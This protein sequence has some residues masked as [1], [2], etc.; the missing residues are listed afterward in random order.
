VFNNLK[1]DDAILKRNVNDSSELQNVISLQED[2]KDELQDVTG[3]WFLILILYNVYIDNSILHGDDLSK[4]GLEIEPD[5][6]SV[7]TE[8][9]LEFNENNMK[10]D[11]S[12]KQVKNHNILS[13]KEIKDLT[14]YFTKRSPIKI[15]E[16]K[17]LD[18]MRKHI[19][20]IQYNGYQ[21]DL[22]TLD[23]LKKYLKTKV[24]Y[25]TG[26]KVIRRKTI[27][28]SMIMISQRM[29]LHK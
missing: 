21:H 24:R 19:N 1:D 27:L 23:Q 22:S 16:D 25:G 26:L 4:L 20:G 6:T 17:K 9:I 13:V 29:A 18:G 7:D 5:D 11:E 8:C 12:M 28:K 15:L 2:N 3:K 14:K 10:K